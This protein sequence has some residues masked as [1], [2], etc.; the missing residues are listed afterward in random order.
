[1]CI[2]L[3]LCGVIITAICTKNALYTS[4]IR[5]FGLIGRLLTV[6]LFT[7]MPLMA[8]KVN[9]LVITMM[10]YLFIACNGV[11][12]GLRTEIDLCL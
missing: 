6:K 3:L 1:M 2:C 5:E 10:H 7:A 8:T 4:T 11:V 12:I 9:Q